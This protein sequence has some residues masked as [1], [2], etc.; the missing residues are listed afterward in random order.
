M[1]AEAIGI[2]GIQSRISELRSLVE[3]TSTS[4]SSTSSSTDT[5][6]ATALAAAL[7]SSGST[8]SATD[9]GDGTVTGSDLVAAAKKYQGVPY[10]WGGESLSEGGL[11]CSGLVQRSLADLGIT[12]V[13]RTAREQ[14]T[15]GQE[16]G[17]LDEAQAGDLLIFNNGTHVGIY[18]G[19]GQ[20]IDAPKPGKTVSV[21]DVY[22]TP[23][24]IRRILP[25]TT[26]TSVSQ[27]SATLQ[28]AMQSSSTSSLAS[29][30]GSS[31]TSS[32][33]SLLGSG[34]SDS[35]SL[36]SIL[37]LSSSSSTSSLASLLGSSVS[38][39]TLAAATTADAQRSALSV[40]AGLSS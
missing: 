13:P 24:T 6:F 39:S 11:D 27:T 2:A 10:V 4:T 12:D 33:A 22:E 18:V 14:A 3:P 37:G 9:L 23:T 36:A 30:L 17:S 20:M 34:S 8:T 15:L 19:D 7:G 16:V 26:D 29:L 5:D 40:L 35:S 31:S 28:S 32:L 38:A 25:Q 1:S 21:R